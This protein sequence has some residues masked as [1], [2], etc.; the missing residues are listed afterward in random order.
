MADVIDLARWR[1]DTNMAAFLR[2]IR[3]GET[4][5]HDDAYR[6]LF[7]GELIDSF[8]DHPRRKVTKQLGRQT[9]TSTAAG[10][11][12]FLSRTWDGL[13]KLWGFRNFEPSTQDLACVALIHGRRA[14]DDVLAG[15]FEAAVAKC[16]RE[17]ASLPGSPYGQPVKTMAQARAVYE[18]WGGLY[19]PQPDTP[20]VRTLDAQPIQLSEVN[21]MPLPLFAA[22]ALPLLAEA[23]PVIG[24]LFGSGS[25]VSERNVKA[26]ELAINVVTQAV[27]AKNAQEAAEIVKADPTMA[28]A[29]GKAVEERWFEL[30]EAG[31]GGIE[32]ARAFVQSAG[33]GPQGDL[34]WKTLRVVT[35]CALGFL[36]IANVIAVLAWGLAMWRQTGVDGAT[37]MMVQ[38]LQADIGCAISAISFWLGS[39]FGSR[40][41][42]EQ[43][44]R[45]QLPAGAR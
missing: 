17:W 7:G 30:Q 45:P 38:V 4:G 41:K 11:Y 14:I 3:A 5:Q 43:Q 32:G 9:L 31:G 8:A 6:M 22:A 12:Q 15:R 37:Q 19:Q 27:G 13:V 33:A 16:A 36:M 24:K 26:A 28:Q 40:Q 25:E 21:D 35:Y 1:A 2:V 20:S 23:I 42:D 34:V 10:A 29:A 18:Q 39:S 44:Q